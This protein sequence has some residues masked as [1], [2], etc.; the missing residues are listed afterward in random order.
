MMLSVSVAIIVAYDNIV[1][2]INTDKMK[3]QQ[4][5]PHKNENDK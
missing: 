4:F 2:K 1:M 5:C 3:L